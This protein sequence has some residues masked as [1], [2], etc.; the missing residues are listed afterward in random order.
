MAY[1]FGCSGYL[2]NKKLSQPSNMTV[3]RKTNT[4]WLNIILVVLVFCAIGF[5]WW[6]VQGEV[7]VLE[8]PSV[9]IGE[10]RWLLEGVSM[11]PEDRSRGLGYRSQLPAGT[12]MLFLFE[13]PDRYA[14]WMRGMQFPIDI[15]FIHGTVVDSV[16]RHRQPGDLSPVTPKEPVTTVLEVNAGE[17]SGVQVGDEVQIVH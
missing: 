16:F 3:E 7:N 13:T 10:N 15:I 14:F 4:F 6:L 9:T 17:A 8:Q 2:R 12:G 11:T 5:E 1:C